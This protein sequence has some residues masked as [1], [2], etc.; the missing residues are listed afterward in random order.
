MV[1]TTNTSFHKTMYFEIQK[2]NEQKYCIYNIN[3]IRYLQTNKICC[4]LLIN[5]LQV[6]QIKIVRSHIVKKLHKTLEKP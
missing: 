1:P 3:L 6:Y 4:F 2:Y 5:N